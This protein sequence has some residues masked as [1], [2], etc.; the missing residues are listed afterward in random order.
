MEAASEGTA[1]TVMGRFAYPLTFAR[2]FPRKPA[3]FFV[4]LMGYLRVRDSMTFSMYT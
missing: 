4:C 2:I 1:V 3:S